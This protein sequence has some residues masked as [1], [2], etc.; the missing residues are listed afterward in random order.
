MDVLEVLRLHPARCFKC[1][2]WM[3]GFPAK[4][5]VTDSRKVESHLGYAGMQCGN[6]SS[7]PGGKCTNERF[8]VETNL[9]VIW[10]DD[11]LLAVLAF[12]GVLPF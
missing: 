4:Y 2:A 11:Y 5:K 9:S 12:Y 7:Q 1:R 6:T 3:K 8:K 10:T